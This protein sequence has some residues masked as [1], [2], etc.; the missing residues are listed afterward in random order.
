MS[1]KT[2]MTP[3][4][5]RLIRNL[6]NDTYASFGSSEIHGIGVVAIR[7]IPEET[8]PFKIVNSNMRSEI[9]DVAP[10]DIEDLPEV[11]AEVKRQAIQLDKELQEIYSKER[12]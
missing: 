11:I 2:L 8:D 3:D 4:K 10:E 9:I 5:L 7:D 12:E 6:D 1:T